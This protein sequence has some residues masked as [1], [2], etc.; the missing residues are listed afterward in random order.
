MDLT[1]GDPETFTEETVEE[2]LEKAKAAAQAEV[3]RQ[4]ESERAKRLEAETRASQ[5]EALAKALHDAQLRRLSNLAAKW[6]LWISRLTLWMGF[7]ILALG[8]YVTLPRPFPELPGEWWKLITPVI[9]L[10]FSLFTLLHLVHGTTLKSIVRTLEVR[11]S[12]FLERSLI[13]LIEPLNLT[14]EQHGA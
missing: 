13:R 8:I 5:V 9:L 12:H 2:V 4:L 10:L 3:L 14:D 6:G 1:F 7:L 11:M